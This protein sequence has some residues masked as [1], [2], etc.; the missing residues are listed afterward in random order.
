MSDWD[1]RDG[2]RS[3]S[4]LQNYSSCAHAW[5]LQRV[6]RV[7][8]KTAGW[9]LQGTSV[10]A[11]VEAYELSERQMSL[12]EAEAV[13]DAAWAVDLAEMEQ[14]Q[15]DPKMWMVGGKKSRDTDLSQRWEK[16]RQ[17][18]AD[19]VRGNP[20]DDEW[21]PAQLVPGE[22]AVE[23]PFELDLEGVKVVGFIDSVLE[24]RETGALRVRDVKTGSKLPDNPFQFAT[25]KLAVEEITGFIPETGVYWMCKDGGDTKPYQLARFSRDLVTAWYT[26][27]DTAVKKEVFPG[28]PG[29]HCFTCTVRPYCHYDNPNPLPLPAINAGKADVF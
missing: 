18:V 21:Q 13:F 23:V 16:G 5:W 14:K 24:H 3:V 9:F 1:W 25:Y 27:M 20:T 26:E 22:P 19:Y 8:Q 7:P 17:Q 11:A 29:S 12:S 10:H 15:P 2:H 28:N 6:V 4:Q